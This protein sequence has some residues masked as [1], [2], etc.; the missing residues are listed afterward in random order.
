M[1][2]R[3]LRELSKKTIGVFIKT[4]LRQQ[5]DRQLSASCSCSCDAHLYDNIR[6]DDPERWVTAWR[7][8]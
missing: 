8:C 4:R 3:M 5:S 1:R 2:M 7:P 6:S